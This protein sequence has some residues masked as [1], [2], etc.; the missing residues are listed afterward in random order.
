[1]KILIAEDDLTSRLILENFL[2][3][4]GTTNVVVNGTEAVSAV[5]SA[6][7]D[8]QPYDLIC[9]DI[10]MPEMDGVKA[11]EKIRK[12]EEGRGVTSTYGAKIIMITAL[13]DPKNVMNSFK[14]LCDAYIVKPIDKTM[15]LQ[16]LDEIGLA[17]IS[18]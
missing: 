18:Q 16:K 10:M 12:S 4:Y 9:L 5:R 15:L 3:E 7:K 14:E 8:G 17:R 11:L 2:Q 1:M 6:L 13:D